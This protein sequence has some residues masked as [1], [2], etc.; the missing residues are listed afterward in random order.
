MEFRNDKLSRFFLVVIAIGVNIFLPFEFM[1]IEAKEIGSIIGFLILLDI[2]VL[3]FA[4][5]STVIKIEISEIALIRK[6]LIK[7]IKPEET[8]ISLDS[9]T[10]IKRVRGKRGGPT[11][12]IYFQDQKNKIDK[13]TVSSWDIEEPDIMAEELSRRAKVEIT[14]SWFY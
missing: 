8:R 7:W 12:S 14:N 4:L 1:P 2:L 6:H 11:Y 5:R 9:I 3:Y 10:K 13:V